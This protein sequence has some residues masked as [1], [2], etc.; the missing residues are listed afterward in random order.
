LRTL[1]GEVNARFMPPQEW[2]QLVANLK[3]DGRLTSAPLVALGGKEPLT[4]GGA[5]RL[6][7]I[8]GNHRVLAALE[9]GLEETD[10]LEIVTPIPRDRKRAI[11]LAHNRIAGR[12]DPNTLQKLYEGLGLDAR[13]YTALSDDDFK[14]PEIDLGSLSIGGMKYQEVVLAFLP[15][16]IAAFEQFVDR[17]RTV[18]SA[19]AYL[20]ERADFEAFFTLVTKLKSKRRIVNSAIAVNLLI[21]LAGER[22]DQIEDEGDG[23]T[24]D[25]HD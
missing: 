1:D 17:T 14:L 20:A 25:L 12:D 24:T 11:Q 9:A 15:P 10:V 22:L 18:A 5:D 19:T 21:Q 4:A 2:A 23:Q 6:E 7:V 8:S 13:I 3:H 16:E